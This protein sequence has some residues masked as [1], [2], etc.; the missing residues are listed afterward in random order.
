M[1][2]AQNFSSVGTRPCTSYP[3]RR[4]GGAA[5]RSVTATAI[6]TGIAAF[7]LATSPECRHWFVIPAF[8]CGL[9]CCIDGLKLFSDNGRNLFQP[10]ALVGAFGTYF[11]FV[12]PLLH[13]GRDYWFTTTDYWA[14][15]QSPEDWRTWLGLM[16]ILNLVGLCVYKLLY[17]KFTR[18]FVKKR[19]RQ[20]YA[21]D[22]KAVKS[23][24]LVCSIIIL[25]LQIYVYYHF[26]GVGSFVQSVSDSSLR[27][28][29]D[30]DGLGWLLAIAESFP[31]LFVIMSTVLYKRGF[32]KMSVL[33]WGIYIAGTTVLVL[34]CGGLRGSRGNTVFT[35]VYIIGIIH[36]AVRPLSGRW[37]MSFAVVSLFFMY[38]YGFYKASPGLFSDPAQIVDTL[39][40]PE[41]RANLEQTTHRNFDGVLM[42]DLERS[43]MQA[44]LLYRMMEDGGSI[45]Y[46]YGR[47]YVE[48][49]VD[50]IPFYILRFR[51]PGKLLY[52]T[53]AVFGEG[54]YLSRVSVYTKIYGL[55]GEAMLNFGP[56]SS[57]FAFVLLA[58]AVGYAGAVNYRLG[59]SDSRRFLVPIL[60]I[61]CISVLASDFDNVIFVLLQHALIPAV[62]VMSCSRRVSQRNIYGYSNNGSTRMELRGE[63]GVRIGAQGVGG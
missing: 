14:P 32:E 21:L 60:S 26:G 55:A 62:F 37:I 34:L 41:S 1:P 50:F 42:G 15:K 30:F 20:F 23:Y 11:F 19:S 58:A 39:L 52:G 43:D 56:Y 2:N 27:T 5:W 45:Q 16:A 59:P 3:L 46:A 18:L 24:G 13:V 38:I 53:N 54:T 4:D 10:A 29:S 25:F 49:L 40:S 8:A 12:G 31:I 6:C 28:G 7:A 57:P 48:G 35:I 22:A 9:L 44:Y 61:T 17:E 63:G 51:A 47:T 33:H 36:F